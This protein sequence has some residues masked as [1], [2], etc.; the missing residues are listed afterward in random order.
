MNANHQTNDFMRLRKMSCY[1]G[2]IF[3]G[4]KA[5]LNAIG[6]GVG[7]AFPGEPGAGKLRCKITRSHGYALV[8][9]RIDWCLTPTTRALRREPEKPFEERTFEVW[10]HHLEKDS[11]VDAQRI[12]VAPG[13]VLKDA[14]Y[15]GD[16]RDLIRAG[17]I[18]EYQL[19]GMPGCGKC[20][21]TFDAE[22]LVLKRSAGNWQQP[23]FKIVRK[24]GKKICVYIVPSVE[25]RS[26]S[27]IR[28]RQRQEA[29][30]LECLEAKHAAQR[31]QNGPRP[32]PALR[33][34]W[35]V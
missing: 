16:A 22:G 33:L 7:C 35:S 30:E 4:T 27:H 19:P 21:T 6:F 32:R 11:R 18:H 29:Y 14:H 13:V 9:V 3:T 28:D 17:I 31:L 8:D 34:V 1:W 24:Y 5:Q 20:T 23:G 12:D 10:A 26:L 25:D 2:D 15:Y